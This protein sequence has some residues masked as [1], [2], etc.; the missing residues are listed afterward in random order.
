MAIRQ[1]TQLT[2]KRST[3]PNVFQKGQVACAYFSHSFADAIDFDGSP[4]DAVELGVLPAFCVPVDA[5]IRS[6][7]IT[8][9]IDCGLMSGTYLD[10]TATRT[11]GD[12]LFD[13][14]TLAVAGTRTVNWPDIH[15]L[16]EAGGTG[17]PRSIGL[18]ATAADIAADATDF[19]KLQLWYMAG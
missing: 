17:A 18:I 10:T 7:G 5:V 1:A 13:G 8:N 15:G 12:E 16:I 19:V 4:P 2:S 6:V 14:V 11:T 3:P 9:V